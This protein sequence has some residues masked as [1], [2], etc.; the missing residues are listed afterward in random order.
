MKIDCAAPISLFGRRQI[1]LAGE[2]T[3]E[4]VDQLAIIMRTAGFELDEV[5]DRVAAAHLEG[6]MTD[7][8]S[9]LSTIARR[10]HLG[11]PFRPTE[12]TFVV[13]DECRRTSR[14]RREARYYV[15]CVASVVIS[16]HGMLTEHAEYDRTVVTGQH[17]IEAGHVLLQRG[18]SPLGHADPRPFI[19]LHP[20]D[21]HLTLLRLR[22]NLAAGPEPSPWLGLL[23]RVERDE[24]TARATYATSS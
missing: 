21:G 10:C 2:Y 22:H 8:G 23:T 4:S 17:R 16:G 15:G 19:R 20:T 11:S 14:P 9:W 24:A 7:H 1:V 5:G 6:P 18:W 12:A 3:P 13:L